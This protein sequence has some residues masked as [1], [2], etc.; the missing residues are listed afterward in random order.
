M[1][2]KC[3]ESGSPTTPLPSLPLESSFLCS[4]LDHRLVPTFVL[5]A[6]RPFLERRP[7]SPRHPP[8]GPR[9][10]RSKWCFTS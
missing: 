2:R 6:G 5:P 7:A 9:S 10:S 1:T 8:R 3:N 4:A